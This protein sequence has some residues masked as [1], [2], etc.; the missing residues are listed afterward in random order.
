M[1]TEIV[2]FG[3]FQYLKV[4]L[5]VLKQKDK[6]FFVGTIPAKHFLEIYTVE[7]AEYDIKSRIEISSE[8]DDDSDYF[9]H[10]ITRD[11]KR[12][13]IKAFQRKENNE[14]INEISEFLNSEEYA[15]FPNAIIVTC[16][17]ANDYYGFDDY[18]SFKDYMN[19]NSRN[20]LYSFLEYSKNTY[21]LYVPLKEDSLLIIDGQH[22][23][24]GLEKTNLDIVKDYDLLVT[25][26][27]GYN[28]SVVAKL[29]YT[30]NYTQK[31][32]NKS[33]LY[34]LTGEFSHEINEITFIH[35]VV[36]LLNE[37][38]KSPLYRR[39][40]MLGIIPKA[41]TAY[42]KKYLS[43]SQAFLVEQL[44]KT[45]SKSSERSIYPPV[46]LYYYKNEEHQVEL[47]RFIINYFAAISH[48]R[49]ADWNDPENSVICKTISIGAFMRV[50]HFLFTKLFIEEMNSDPIR[51]SEFTQ[52]RLVDYLSGIERIDF[53]KKGEFGGIASSGSLNKL[54]VR[55]IESMDYF[56]IFCI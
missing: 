28:R 20:E 45:I 51:I 43:V 9:D 55:M 8:F 14:R 27:I 41:I 19:S 26:I 49:E 25:F 6:N 48:I 12:I 54:K 29:F 3:Q 40:K 34:H 16:D 39:I 50:L 30:I 24:K 13:S 52:A 17:L 2:D 15:L 5:I 31:S 38:E 7:P 53:S 11:K 23:V 36:K 22:R 46:F 18:Q 44:I 10:L 33:L 21:F 47:V 37:V 42:D 4:P 1:S 32:V 56:G 35:E